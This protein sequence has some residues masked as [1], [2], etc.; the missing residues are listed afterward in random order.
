MK[1][2][3]MIVRQ[4][5]GNQCF[6]CLSENEL[7]FA[8]IFVWKKDGGKAIKYNG[9]CLCRK[10]HNMLDFQVDCDKQL[11]VNLLELAKL[12]LLTT[13][14]KEIDSQNIMRKVKK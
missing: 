13:Y 14:K 5:E 4:R 10:C 7:T 8:H 12:Y 9:I 3:K 11:S 2:E 6:F 1:E